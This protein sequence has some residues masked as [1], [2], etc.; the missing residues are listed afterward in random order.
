MAVHKTL[1]KIGFLSAIQTQ[2]STVVKKVNDTQALRL[3]TAFPQHNLTFQN[4]Q[5]SGVLGIFI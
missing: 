1:K 4:N 2:M 3:R 5:V